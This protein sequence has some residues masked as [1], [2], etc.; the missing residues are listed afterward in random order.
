[1]FE[2]FTQDA[3]QA[4]KLAQDN[5]RRLNHHFIGGE[6]LLLGLLDRPESVSARLLTRHGLDH[7]RAYRSVFDMIPPRAGDRLDADALET[8][9][10]DLSAIRE[11]VEAAFGPGALDRPPQRTHRGR[12]VSGRHIAFTAPAKKALELSLREALAL[13]HRH[14]SDG[15][16]LLGV[17]RAGPG[18]A[19]RVL[20]GAGIDLETLRQELVAELG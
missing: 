19:H 3:R 10:I 16:L 2:R 7:E 8:I 1:M 14:I 12:L 5:A 4:V 11:R 18:P 6:H 20:S 17:L 9:G 15:H 13:K